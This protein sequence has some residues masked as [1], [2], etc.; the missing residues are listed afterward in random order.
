MTNQAILAENNR[1]LDEFARVCAPI[2][3][4]ADRAVRQF[5]KATYTTTKAKPTKRMRRALGV[6]REI[7]VVVSTFTDQQH[8]IIK[9]IQGLI[10]ASEGRLEPSMA[11][12]IHS[13]QDGNEKLRTWG[14]DH[15]I[16]VLGVCSA[17]G[18]TT[19]DDVERML[20]ADLYSHDPFDVTGPVS[21]E[22]N[23]YGRR[24]IAIELARK[25]QRGEIR[26]CL[27]LRKAGKTSVVNRVVAEMRQ[28]Y[29]CLCALVD[30]SRDDIWG[31][32]AASLMKAIA[33][34]LGQ[35]SRRHERYVAVT[36]ARK[37]HNISDA[38]DQLVAA[39]EASGVPVIIVF[40]EID[41]ISPASPTRA[42]WAEDFNPFWR[43]LR[44]AYQECS[45]REVKLSLF[46]VGVSSHWFTV[47]EIGGVENAALSFV[48]GEYLV[49]LP[50]AA[51][52]GML[53][54]LGAT[55]GLK[56]TDDAADAIAVATNNVPFWT[57][58]CASRLNRTIPVESRPRSVERAEVDPLIAEYLAEEGA[59]L[60]MVAVEHLFRVYPTM[61]DSVLKLRSNPGATLPIG[62]AQALRS[63][64]L[65][66][67]GSGRLAGGLIASGMEAHFAGVS[68]PTG[69]SPMV[70]VAQG[71]LDEWAESI[72]EI[73]KRRNLLERRL[74]DIVLS[75]L[76]H[77]CMVK[78]GIAPRERILAIFPEAQR[79][80]LVGVSAA[81]LMD[82]M[83]WTDLVKLM[84]R[85]WVLFERTF[86]DRNSFDRHC[87]SVNDRFDA[88]AKPADSADFAYYRRSLSYLEE[89][90]RPLM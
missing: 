65:I 83:L 57:R 33:D 35:A 28:R 56:F 19:C 61:R 46:V 68:P 27:G 36:A 6:E 16:V 85:E 21:D 20:C 32:S 59:A 55:A 29:D 23:F 64:G 52:R 76:R 44:V 74:R 88:H 25:L 58:K 10:T 14:R 60:S 87:D 54:R 42:S 78:G 77:D 90:L 22:A 18:L 49:P 17:N 72:A 70:Q 45:R 66:D 80:K 34:A 1:Q 50:T 81:D 62:P 2:F 84:T 63:Y 48:P 82:K 89:K 30:C 5:E 4:I 9:F 41:Y 26:S 31:S 51:S 69:P 37:D 24:D 43:N 71:Q 12:I 67:A 40:D 47:G 15:G 79:S 39:I 13:D 53:Q 3:T 38:R 7:L 73:S 11:I 8:R 75:T 86:G